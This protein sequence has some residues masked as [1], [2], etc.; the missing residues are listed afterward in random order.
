MEV[1]EILTFYL[2]DLGTLAVAYGL[3]SL[4]FLTFRTAEKLPDAVSFFLKMLLGMVGLLV[5]TAL[6][7]TQGLTVLS[8]IVGAYLMTLWL[9]G[10]GV[11]GA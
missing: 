5:L 6:Y 4:L 10:H 2:G 1:M 3:G 8:G 9:G 7:H 11:A